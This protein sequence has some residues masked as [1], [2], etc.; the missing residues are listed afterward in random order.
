M[1]KTSL[2]RAFIERHPEARVLR[3]LCDDLSTPRTLG[4]LL[5]MVG[6]VGTDLATMLARGASPDQ[7]FGLVLTELRRP[8]GP[9]IF[10]IEDLHWADVATLDLIIF[11]VRRIDTLPALLVLS[12]RSEE[13][14]PAQPLLRALSRVPARAAV[15][16][17]LEP[18]SLN[19]VRQ[20]AAGSAEQLYE[21][22]GGNPFYLS[23]VLATP[24]QVPW[25]VADAVMTRVGR[26]APVS[27]RLLELV[28]VSPGRVERSLLDVCSPGWLVAATDP[29]QRGML[30]V[31]PS[32]VAFRHEIARRVVA[33][34]IPAVRSAELHR[35]LL[36]AL[37]ERDADPALI[38]HHAVEVGD[39]AAMAN[40]GLAAAHQ[41]VRYSAHREALAHFRRLGRLTDR[42]E[43]AE[44]AEIL[45]LWSNTCVQTADMDESIE[46]STR[47]LELRRSL[48]DMT[49]IARVLLFLAQI[50]WAVGDPEAAERYLSEAV[51]AAA[52]L[53]PGRERAD[54]LAVLA[55][56][57]MVTWEFD[58][59]IRWGTEAAEM[60][61]EHGADDVL[62][63]A[64][65]AMGTVDY[66]CGRDG[67]A[68]A[69][70]GIELARDGGYSHIACVGYANLAETAVELR[71]YH[72][73]LHYLDVGS[74]W[75]DEHEVLSVLGYLTG[76]RSRLEFERGRW[77]DAVA[78]ATAVL[79]GTGSTPL[80]DLNALYA[81]AGVQSRRGAPE[82]VE[83]VRRYVAEAEQTG[84]LQR[85]VTA[86]VLQAA[87]A[88]L[89]GTLG[90]QRPRLREVYDRV[91]GTG[92][93]AALGELARWLARAGER[94]D[95][96]AD[97]LPAVRHEL[98]RDWA[99]AAAA[100]EELGCPYDQADALAHSS[101]GA[102]LLEALTIFDGIGAEAVAN[103]VREQL[104]QQ[105]VRQIPR[106]PRPAT[107]ANPAGLTARQVDVLELVA[108]GMTN[109]EIA[110][111]LFVSVR[112][113]D[114][115]V[116]AILTKLEVSSRRQAAELARQ[117]GLG[118]AEP[119]PMP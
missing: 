100:W 12:Y 64:L 7:L 107:R 45:E 44:R 58:N 42:F 106:G 35:V 59:A 48:G 71:R 91:I 3:G 117:L 26:L 4:P 55:M 11:L 60:A 2:I 113:V 6:E 84:E 51:A 118:R 111:R 79:T 115:H 110:D 88:E 74:A 65:I 70:R 101:D 17:H 62:A 43:P 87:D 39:V 41:A 83:S 119:V 92:E 66:A 9:T 52:D 53:A 80:N 27:R 73:A 32:W 103:R 67:L 96:P 94:V 21:L 109:A 46:M 38:V 25:S 13:L 16:I 30:E 76:V 31:G 34:Q 18:L 90:A 82:A 114:H 24:D 105:G 108:Q 97:V 86:A 69:E 102:A 23:E 22:T 68:T 98:A 63:T 81:L 75:A 78:L 1:G 14:D 95:P 116:A 93:V 77:D 33:A 40:Y 72:D 29:E 89:A 56:R 50:H 20:L 15:R 5:D 85:L 19:A 28:A 36:D 112:T 54:T 99:A 49:G 8:P 57:A 10:V 61:E 37:V 47:A 104:R